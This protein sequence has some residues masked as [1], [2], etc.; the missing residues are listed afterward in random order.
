MGTSKRQMAQ[1]NV[2]LR[3]PVNSAAL[4]PDP[5]GGLAETVRICQDVTLASRSGQLEGLP[6]VGQQ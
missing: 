1:R 2:T 5:A 6:S 3:N 4:A